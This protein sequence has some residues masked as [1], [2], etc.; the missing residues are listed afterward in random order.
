MEQLKGRDYQLEVLIQKRYTSRIK[1]RKDVFRLIKK[2]KLQ[3]NHQWHTCATKK[4]KVRI[5][6]TE[7]NYLN[8]NSDL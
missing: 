7:G 2:N 4:K 1:V 6:Q 3:R 5:L 8:V